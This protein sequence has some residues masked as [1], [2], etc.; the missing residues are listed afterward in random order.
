MVLLR[1]PYVQGASTSDTAQA[2]TTPQIRIDCLTLLLLVMAQLPNAQD[3]GPLAQIYRQKDSNKPAYLVHRPSETMLHEVTQAEALLGLQA[4]LSK[5][6]KKAGKWLD[7]RGVR[8]DVVWPEPPSV[9]VK[10]PS[11]RSP[12]GVSTYKFV[13]PHGV[14]KPTS[15]RQM[16]IL[17][18][19]NPYKPGTMSDFYHINGIQE[20]FH[21]CVE[22]A[23]SGPPP[24]NDWVS[25]MF[26]PDAPIVEKMLE[27]GRTDIP[28]Y[29][30]VNGGVP[31]NVC[32]YQKLDAAMAALLSLV[33]NSTMEVDHVGGEA[34]SHNNDVL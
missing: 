26:I 22:L 14:E 21:N 32:V 3:A 19:P 13:W 11:S 12:S 15:K 31:S 10:G 16:W 18:E 30:M 5:A 24:T 33:A 4:N 1:V 8:T 7:K 34:P 25:S 2:P 23:E 9:E 6:M 27:A 28:V 29:F 17:R 20:T